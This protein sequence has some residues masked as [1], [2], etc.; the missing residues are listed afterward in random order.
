MDR[1]ERQQIGVNKWIEHGCKGILNWYPAVGKTYGAI[2]AIKTI[3]KL[4]KD[5]NINFFIIV[6]SQSVKDQWIKI[7]NDNLTNTII[8][9]IH[10]CTVNE[11]LARIHTAEVD[12]LIIDEIHE[13]TTDNKLKIIDNTI[14]KYKSILGLSGSIDSKS[15]EIIKFIVPVIDIIDEEE[16]IRNNWASPYLEYNLSCEFNNLEKEEYDKYTSIIDSLFVKFE[17]RLDVVNKCLYGGVHTDNREY[18]HLQFCIG[19][20]VKNGWHNH[21]NLAFK[22]HQEIDRLWNPTTIHKE[23]I[24]LM[25]NIRKRS[26]LLYNNKSK[27]LLTLELLKKLN[28]KNII[29]FGE[30]TTFADKIHYHSLSAGLKA[31]IFHSQL[32]TIMMTSEKTGKLIKYGKTR[33]KAKALEEI[34]IGSSNILITARSFDI[35]LS[36]NSLNCGIITSGSSNINQNRQRKGRPTRE[37]ILNPKKQSLIINIYMKNTQEEKWLAERQMG[38]LGVVYID[39]LDQ[40]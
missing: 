5:S 32:K 38:S 9:R 28:N 1:N 15:S 36:I 30:S 11:C 4:K 18:T 13:Y 39:S 25:N 29:V 24:L 23:A 16:A 12:V 22:E 20:S 14:I 33:L 35:G 17:K 31:V 34:T 26:E 27:L 2:K 7:I 3:D 10:L 6:N 21:L 19:I 37:D 8:N 40:I